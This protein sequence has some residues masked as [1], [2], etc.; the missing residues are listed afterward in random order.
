MWFRSD[1]TPIAA[2]VQLS[3][4]RSEDTHA[5]ADVSF[6]LPVLDIILTC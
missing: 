5:S 1:L 6:H 3:I 4:D 2:L